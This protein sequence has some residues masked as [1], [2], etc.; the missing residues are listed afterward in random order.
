VLTYLFAIIIRRVW[1]A[2]S[3]SYGLWVPIVTSNVT[4]IPEVVDNAAL[5][6]DPYDP[7]DIAEKMDIA[8]SMD[9]QQLVQKGLERVAQFTWSKVAQQTW[10][11]I[12]Q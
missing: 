8:L 2:T 10:I 6:C 3:R 5:L 9:R 12:A 1:L 4:S 7:T 11:C